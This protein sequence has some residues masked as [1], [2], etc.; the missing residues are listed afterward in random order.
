MQ[1]KQM[2][3]NDCKLAL[4]P[5]SPQKYLRHAADRS[6]LSDLEIAKRSGIPQ[7]TVYRMLNAITFRSSF[8]NVAMVCKTLNIPL[9]Y[10]SPLHLQTNLQPIG[11][12]PL[13]HLPK[14]I[15]AKASKMTSA[16]DVERTGILTD[17]SWNPFFPLGTVVHYEPIQDTRTVE[18][19]SFVVSSVENPTGTKLSLQLVRHSEDGCTLILHG[20]DH[21]NPL[22]LQAQYAI[23]LEQK[24]S[25]LDPSVVTIVGTVQKS[26]TTY[27]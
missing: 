5:L 1:A 2:K 14:K 12:K 7:S 11:H 25:N 22:Y 3:L 16:N 15:F 6:G 13:S 23:P 9:P 21:H 24:A 27:F 10:D 20:L 18:H 26:M 8:V 17:A 19:N 4:D